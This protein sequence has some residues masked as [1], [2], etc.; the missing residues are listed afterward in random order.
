MLLQS[1]LT[2]GTRGQLIR[3]ENTPLPDCGGEC[4][5]SC[6]QITGYSSATR[7]A[8]PWPCPEKVAKGLISGR[9]QVLELLDG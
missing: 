8:V 4:S 2:P 7:D 5:A 6:R 1:L 9:T 3:F